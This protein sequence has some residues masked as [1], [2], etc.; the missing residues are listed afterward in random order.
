MG[1]FAKDTSVT[2]EQSMAEIK[3]TLKRWGASG[4]AQ[5]EDER[6]VK[7]GFKTKDRQVKFSLPLPDMNSDEF[8]RKAG[9]QTGRKGE[10][11]EKQYDQ[12][13]R[14]RYR[15]LLL[16]IKAKLESVETG[17]ETFEEAFMAQ[18]VLPDGRTMDE[19]A[20]PQIEK[21]YNGQAMPHHFCEQ[22]QQSQKAAFMQRLAAGDPDAVRIY[23]AV[24]SA[25]R[26]GKKQ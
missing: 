21:I 24:V 7:I 8:I 4:L 18:L 20:A 9:N 12:A 10:F 25:V 6:C 1:T 23:Q 3:A 19:W 22:C 5:Y 14:Q 26:G 16:T 11:S 17:I 13:V 2:P 15:A